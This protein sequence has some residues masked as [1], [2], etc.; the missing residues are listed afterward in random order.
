MVIASARW[1]RMQ[2]GRCLEVNPRSRVMS[3]AECSD[4]DSISALGTNA[5]WKM[6]GS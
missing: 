1:E 3:L 4:G 6:S 2:T 5:D